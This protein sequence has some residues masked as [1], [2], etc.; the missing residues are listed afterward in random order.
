ME[1]PRSEVRWRTFDL[2]ANLV[3]NVPFNQKVLLE[4]GG[5]EKLLVAV[6]KDSSEKSRVK[7]LYA[8]SCKIC[9]HS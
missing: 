2:I 1:H 9:L 6:D 5:V 3:Q 7:A 8:L 4:M